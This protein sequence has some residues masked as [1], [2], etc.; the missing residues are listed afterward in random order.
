MLMDKTAIGTPFV[1]AEKT[2]EYRHAPAGTHALVGHVAQ[3]T[4]TK[5]VYF[6]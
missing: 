3:K 2:P 6:L 5:V 4:E 1:F